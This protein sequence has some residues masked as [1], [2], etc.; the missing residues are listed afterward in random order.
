LDDAVVT[1]AA[2]ILWQRPSPRADVDPCRY[3]PCKLFRAC[4]GG[5]T[6]PLHF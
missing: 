4:G 2:S 6:G 3:D 1:E 5:P